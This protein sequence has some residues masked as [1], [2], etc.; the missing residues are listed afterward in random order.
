MMPFGP[1]FRLPPVEEVCF[2]GKADPF[3]NAICHFFMNWKSKVQKI[4]ELGALRFCDVANG[5]TLVNCGFGFS[6]RKKLLSVSRNLVNHAS[7]S[8]V[9]IRLLLSGAGHDEIRLVPFT[10]TGH[11]PLPHAGV[12]NRRP[13]RFSPVAL[14]AT[15]RGLAD[16][17]LMVYQEK[18]VHP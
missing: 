7:G 16:N 3:R 1:A 8:I 10:F 6:C 5:N 9:C 14:H 13:C 15:A 2:S 11:V 17:A 4:S 12:P 18:S